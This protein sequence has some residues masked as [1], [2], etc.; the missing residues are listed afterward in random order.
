ME[1][2][3]ALIRNDTEDVVSAPVVLEQVSVTQH[4]VDLAHAVQAHRLAQHAGSVA[5]YD[6]SGDAGHRLGRGAVGDVRDTAVADISAA[7]CWGPRTAARRVRESV[8]AVCHTPLLIDALADGAIDRER[9]AAVVDALE[10]VPEGTRAVVAPHVEAAM[11]SGPRG[12][13]SSWTATATRKRARAAVANQDA[14]SPVR[15][16]RRSVREALGV[17]FEPGRIRGT[18][19]MTATLPTEQAA[20]MQ[21]AIQD[22]AGRYRNA[23][24]DKAATGQ[25]ETGAAEL[26]AS[27]G[28]ARRAPLMGECRAQALVDLLTSSADA[29]ASCTFLVPVQEGAAR[30]AAVATDGLADL[31]DQTNLRMGF[32]A[33]GETGP[34]EPLDL[35]AW[36]LH[37]AKGGR[38]PD[39]PDPWTTTDLPP[40][41]PPG[42][43]R[44]APA[45]TS[46]SDPVAEA[47]EELIER[48][49]TIANQR[50]DSEPPAA[51][52]DVVVDGVGVI[53][54]ETVTG[55][56]HALGDTIGRALVSPTTGALREHTSTAYR[57][58][59]RMRQFVQLRDQVCRFPGCTRPAQMTDTDHVI[60][61]GRGGRTEPAG[62]LSLCRAHHRAKHSGAWT[63]TITPDGTAT[64]TSASS[65]IYITY[66]AHEPPPF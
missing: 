1:S 20:A 43:K 52:G 45:A 9:L 36:G 38:V 32:V 8:A 62:L 55:L 50:T 16:R 34:G 6:P 65:R 33:G 26:P 13:I 39:V 3:Y 47:V 11:L 29:S 64:W 28:D 58:P 25:A 46:G 10:D 21:S 18:S 19:T 59:T 40:W 66:P 37:P 51:L 4:L 60:P 31:L 12:G 7:L 41:H 27:A 44:A 54:A 17:W 53:S 49:T 14:E 35:S 63:V 15:H 56:V 22:L 57:P 24:D 23:P 61:H 2:A 30:A 48:L 5:H 42:T